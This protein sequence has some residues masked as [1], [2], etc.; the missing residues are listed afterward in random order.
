M[1]RLDNPATLDVLYSIVG[2]VTTAGEAILVGTFAP[3]C[4][5]IFFAFT[6]APVEATELFLPMVTEPLVAVAPTL[7]FSTVLLFDNDT[8]DKPRIV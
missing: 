1:V 3:F 6:N 2:T 5:V 8:P 4:T 7:P